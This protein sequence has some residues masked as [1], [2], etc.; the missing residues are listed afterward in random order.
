MSKPLHVAGTHRVLQSRACTAQRCRPSLLGAGS[1]KIGNR[2][3]LRMQRSKGPTVAQVHIFDGGGI[4]Q[5][6]ICKSDGLLSA[7]GN[8]GLQDLVHALC[9]TILGSHVQAVVASLCL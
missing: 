8:T 1:I 7:N 9:V 4:G 6:N 5:H 3:T 2:Q